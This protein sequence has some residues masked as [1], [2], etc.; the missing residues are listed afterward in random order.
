MRIKPTITVEIEQLVQQHSERRIS[1][2]AGMKIDRI[3]V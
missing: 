2:R 1:T 3:E